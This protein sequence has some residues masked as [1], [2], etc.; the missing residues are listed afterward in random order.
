MDVTELITCERRMAIFSPALV[1]SMS[2]MFI[3]TRIHG[4]VFLFEI[5]L[6]F[7]L[8]YCQCPSYRLMEQLNSSSAKSSVAILPARRVKLGQ[9]FFAV[10]M[11]LPYY[12]DI[13]YILCLSLAYIVAAAFEIFLSC[14]YPSM[15]VTTRS[16]FVAFF[17]V[18]YTTVQLWRISLFLS[19][20]RVMLLIS[21]LSMLIV[22]VLLSLAEPQE[23]FSALHQAFFIMLRSRVGLS[24]SD[25]ELWSVRLSFV[26]RAFSVV[27]IAAVAASVIVP[28]RRFSLLDHRLHREFLQQESITVNQGDDAVHVGGDAYSLPPPTLRTI[29]IIA[30]DYIGTAVLLIFAA[31]SVAGTYARPLPLPFSPVVLLSVTVIVRLATTRLR[32]QAFLD[33]ALDAFR[34]YSST[35]PKDFNNAAQLL[36]QTVNG[37][38][39]YLAMIATAFV[40]PSVIVLILLIVTTVDG[41]VG[42]VGSFSRGGRFCQS[43]LV[44]GPT[45]PF[46]IFIGRIAG[47]GAWIVSVLYVAFAMFSF[48]VEVAFEGFSAGRL[49]AKNRAR[50]RVPEPT[51]SQRRKL[52]RI[53]GSSSSSTGASSSSK[54]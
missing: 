29:F 38:V 47:F 34:R 25:S 53:V 1:I 48:A 32:L 6:F 21:A 46:G 5:P 12:R 54:N 37:T 41:E 7:G 31:A 19:S 28:S 24:I 43:M 42:S 14:K 45:L 26:F 35:R 49:S 18:A 9:G 4:Y 16:S 40:G 11:D 39:Q 2:V 3:I 44:Q 50:A 23:A 30:V 15:L 13:H 8:K 36:I 27:S 20:K 33:G 17:V 22:L 52:R 10:N 51:A